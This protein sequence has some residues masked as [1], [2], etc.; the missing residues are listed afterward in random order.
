MQRG[1]R[2]GAAAD[3][4]GHA[5]RAADHRRVGRRAALLGD[6]GMR[7]NHAVHVFGAGGGARQHHG[8]AAR[9][10]LLGTVGIADHHAGADA[11]A[12]RLA[13]RQ[14]RRARGRAIGETRLQERADLFGLHARERRARVDAPLVDHVDREA[15]GGLRRAL[16]G[17]G[18]QHEELAVLHGELDVLHVAIVLFEQ[19]LRLVELRRTRR[20]CAP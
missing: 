5:Q 1:E 6:D 3:D 8:F 4:A 15:H 19:Q 9:G 17:T 20:A 18:L 16:G 11:L 2:A 12:G 14:H 10:T 7:G 13:L